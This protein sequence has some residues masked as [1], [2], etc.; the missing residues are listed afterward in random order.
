MSTPFDFN[1]PQTLDFCAGPVTPGTP[2]D[3]RFSVTWAAWV[4]DA[5]IRVGKSE[6]ITPPANTTGSKSS[7]YP[8]T[9]PTHLSLSFDKDALLSIAIQKTATQIEIKRYTDAGDPSQI[10]TVTFNGISPLLFCNWLTYFGE[11]DDETDSVCFYLKTNPRNV[12]FARF[13]GENFATEY[14]IN[15]GLPVNLNYLIRTYAA[16]NKQVLLAKSEIGDNV[17]IT[18]DLYGIIAS[19]RT[20]LALSIESGNYFLSAVNATITLQDKATI[21]PSL[22]RITDAIT[23]NTVFPVSPAL[24]KTTLDVSIIQGTYS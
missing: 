7:L 18:S 1:K 22:L 23:K 24:E 16:N 6:N 19:D 20:S 14:V 12:I 10:A 5:G 13:Q 11:D 9:K 8:T 2:E 3:D 17:T 21:T 15:A 4:S